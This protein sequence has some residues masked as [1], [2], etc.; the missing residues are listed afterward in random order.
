MAALPSTYTLPERQTD[1][2]FKQWNLKI[3]IYQ[4]F[5]ELRKIW[6]QTLS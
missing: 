3:P 5:G 6:K 4:L 2:S 1:E